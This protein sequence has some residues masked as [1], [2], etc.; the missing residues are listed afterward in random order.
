MDDTS[1]A[2]QTVYQDEVSSYQRRRKMAR[3][4]KDAEREARIRREIIVDAYGPEEQALGWYNYLADTLH[5]PF[6]AHCVARRAISPLEPGD[7]FDVVGMAPEEECRHEMFVMTRWRPH[8]LAVPLMQ[9]EGIHV[10]EET[11]QA[12][13]DWHYWVNQGNEF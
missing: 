12:I 6:T 8:E 3:Q 5:F 13:E 2:P 9:V 11:Q 10:A 7:E 4:A 1:K